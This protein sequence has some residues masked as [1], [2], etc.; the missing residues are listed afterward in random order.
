MKVDVGELIHRLGTAQIGN[1][2]LNREIAIAIK[3]APCNLKPDIVA[4]LL[5]GDGELDTINRIEKLL[6][7]YTGSIDAALTIVPPSGNWMLRST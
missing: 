1:Q 6:P 7:E 3:W 2:Q 4:R 5:R